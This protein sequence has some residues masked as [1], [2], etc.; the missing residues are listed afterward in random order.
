[1]SVA[2]SFDVEYDGDKLLCACT[3]WT[4][5]TLTVPQLWSSSNKDGFTELSQQTFSALLETLWSAHC[6]GVVILSWGGTGSDWPA[7]TKMAKNQSQKEKIKTMAKASVDIPLISA[8]SSGMMMGL[9]SASMGMGMGSRQSCDSEHVPLF[10]NSGDPVKQN[11]VL[12]HV[13]W[14]SMA[15]AA[16]YN[17]LYFTAQSSRP[18]LHWITQKSGP[19]TVRLPRMRNEDGTYT[20]PVVGEM[21][22]WPEPTTSFRI[23]DHLNPQKIMRWLV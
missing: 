12:Q 10:W 18:S 5:G 11:E 4:N 16:I 21:L 20:L 14:D 2:L 6:S 13:I 23:P 3:A 1:M 8:A 9:V 22:T 17:K 7:M 19:R 15:C